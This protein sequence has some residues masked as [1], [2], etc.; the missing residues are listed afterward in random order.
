MALIACK[1]CNAQVSDTAGKCPQCGAKVKKKMSIIQWVGVG[2]FG[3][4]IIAAVSGKK[5]GTT[6]TANTTSEQQAEPA[7][8]TTAQQI[9]AMYQKNEIAGDNAFKGKALIVSGVVDGVDSDFSNNAVVRLETSNQFMTV[10]AKIDSSQ[11][12]KAA[13]IEK[14]QKISLSCTGGGEVV[15]SPMLEDCTF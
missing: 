13:S 5:E 9:F 2:F 1:E 3:L 4:I 14:G 8:Q 12:A 15:G 7:I 11:K 6:S 10:M